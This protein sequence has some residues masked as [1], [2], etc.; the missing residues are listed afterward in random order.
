MAIIRVP[1]DGAW[2]RRMVEIADAPWSQENLVASFERFGWTGGVM[3][4]GDGTPR[5][6]WCGWADLLPGER[7]DKQYSGWTMHFFEP[8]TPVGEEYSP[9]AG[10]A[11]FCGSLWPAHDPGQDEGEAFPAADGDDF[12]E[13]AGA[14]AVWSV[15]MQ[16]HRDDFIAEFTRIEALLRDRCGEPSAVL[17]NETEAATTWDRGTARLCLMISPNEVNYGIDD[18][19]SLRV[20]PR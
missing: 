19:I 17:R 10:I 20:I 6:P 9:D 11:L 1:V 15:D 5:L 12:A 7:G 13:S 14:F 18:W 4:S 8:G 3:R 2:V 16:A